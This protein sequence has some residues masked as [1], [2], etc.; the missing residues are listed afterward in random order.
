VEKSG[1]LGQFD[2][3]DVKGCGAVSHK[4]HV[5]TAD[6]DVG[7]NIFFLFSIL[8]EINYLCT[9]SLKFFP[10]RISQYLNI[11]KITVTYCP[12]PRQAILIAVFW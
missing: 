11:L 4:V 6:L 10:K 9:G 1:A 2:S 12:S 7:Y 3:M 5:H 8:T